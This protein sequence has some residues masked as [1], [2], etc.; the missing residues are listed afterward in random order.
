MNLPV[1]YR[2]EITK[3]DIQCNYQ[4]FWVLTSR[5]RECHSSHQT[6]TQKVLYD[7]GDTYEFTCVFECGRLEEERV[8]GVGVLLSFLCLY[9]SPVH[10]V[11]LVPHQAQHWEIKGK[12]LGNYWGK[13]EFFTSGTGTALSTS[14]QKINCG[15]NKL[16]CLCLLNFDKNHIIT[17]PHPQT[18]TYCQVTCYFAIHLFQS[19]IYGGR[20][21]KFYTEAK[22]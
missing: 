13:W 12:L 6:R 4:C 10:Q 8:D 7:L 1:F 11:T 20:S 22:T 9:L 3:W 17:I 21:I 15:T 5:K 16:I 19:L 18:T 2:V 14:K